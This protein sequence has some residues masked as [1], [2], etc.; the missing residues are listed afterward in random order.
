[1]FGWVVTGKVL[2]IERNEAFVGI[3]TE[4]SLEKQV[5][6]FWKIEEKH[7]EANPMTQL[8]QSC[9]KFFEETTMRNPNNGK[10]IVKLQKNRQCSEILNK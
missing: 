9:E 7:Q 3:S 6:Q 1:M 4:Q 5:S 10:F 2:G 8:E